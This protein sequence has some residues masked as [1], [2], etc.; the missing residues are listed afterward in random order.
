[1]VNG[2]NRISK[3]HFH[4]HW[5]PCAA[6]KGHVVTHFD[7]PAQKVRRRIVRA[8]KAAALFPRPV[9]GAVRPVVQCPTQ[10]YSMKRRLGRGFTIEECRTAGVAPSVLR[11]MGVAVDSRR[12]NRCQESLALN[13]ARLKAYLA[14][15]VL[16]PLRSKR[17]CKGDAAKAECDRVVAD[18]LQDTSRRGTM[19]RPKDTIKS[20]SRPRAPTAEEKKHHV[21]QFMRLQR[22]QEHLVGIKEKRAKRKA[23]AAAKEKEK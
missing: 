16:F 4:K 20:D 10:R 11:T 23:A 22:R 21:Y 3:N 8:R 13:S 5:N 15:L 18:K 12:V 19:G 14:K 7:Q 6:Q 9:S 2:N 1:M 17:P